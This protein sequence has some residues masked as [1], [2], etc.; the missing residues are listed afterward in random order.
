MGLNY[1]FGD[2]KKGK[3]NLITDV[4]G[5]KVA[6]KTITRNGLNTGVTAII[7][8]EDNIFDKKIVAGAHIINGFA[9]CA[10]VIQIGEL[11]NIETPVI[12]TST[13]SLGTAMVALSKYGVERSPWLKKEGMTISPM[14]LEC[15]DA[16]LSDTYSFP[17]TEQDVYDALSD[18]SEEFEEGAVGAGRGMSTYSLKGGIG[19]SSRIVEIDGKEYTIGCI[20]NT[21]F[22]TFE[23]FTLQGKRVMNYVDEEIEK[24]I[25]KGSIVIFIATDIPMSTNQLNRVSRRAQSAIAKTGSYSAHNSGEIVVAISTANRVDARSKGGVFEQKY[26]NP[27]YINIVFKAT[28]EMVEEAIISSMA[29]AQEV[30]GNSNTRRALKDIIDLDEF[31]ERE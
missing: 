26:L 31:M 8:A 24:T 29:H 25:D 12:M 5:V 30:S 11:G 20:T 7:P 16:Y 2:F 9:K 23:D 18:V 6:H 27:E 14:V 17:I 3:R 28:V 1:K 15:N 10:G 21:N 4:K 22:G 19:S 13:L